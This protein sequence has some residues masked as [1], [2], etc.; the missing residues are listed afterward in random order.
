MGDCECIVIVTVHKKNWVS[1][2]PAFK[3]YNLLP[4]IKNALFPAVFCLY[5][6]DCIDILFLVQ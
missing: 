1:L 4:G 5:C 6:N 3:H 2:K